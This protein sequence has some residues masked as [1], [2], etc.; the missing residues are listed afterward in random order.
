MS[1]EGG[2]HIDS[3]K[4]I[5]HNEYT[6]AHCNAVFYPQWSSCQRC[7]GTTVT[8]KDTVRKPRDN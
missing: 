3:V 8:K 4:P 2:K 1:K 5:R 6:C 7:G